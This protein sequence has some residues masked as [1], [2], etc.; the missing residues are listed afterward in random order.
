[1][2]V[3]NLKKI[4][5]RSPY[6]ISVAPSPDEGGDGSEPDTT[7]TDTLVLNRDTSCGSTEEVG[8]DVGVRK[9]NLTAAQRQLGDYTITFSNI[10][11]PIKFRIGHAD[12][13]PA[14]S[15]AGLDSY[16]AAWTTATGESPTLSSASANP[17]GVSAT[18]TY[19]STQSDIDTYGNTITLEIL[20]PLIVEGYSFVSSCPAALVEQEPTLTGFVT[21]L[22]VTG[23]KVGSDVTATIN[24]VS[25]PN[26]PTS[27][28]DSVRY[29]F[30]DETPNL[31]PKPATGNVDF[32]RDNFG[33]NPSNFIGSE[34]NY[35]WQMSF[36]TS[37]EYLAENR[38]SRGTNRVTFSRIE[39]TQ[40]I[41]YSFSVARHPVVDISGTNYILGKADEE[42]IQ[43]FSSTAIL[44]NLF[45]ASN[46]V[47]IYWDGGNTQELSNAS[48]GGVTLPVRFA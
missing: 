40:E 34:Y 32:Q 33:V 25:L 26:L 48:V 23:M 38:L 28:G 13:M 19:T 27:R 36:D 6:Y 21:V 31:V 39:R 14:Y 12:N 5:V 17:N 46:T 29:I 30:S 16:A 45:G 44:Y 11:V 4:N 43:V 10:K 18:A 35:R 15:T 41:G 1:M 3:N 42:M 7:P 9:Y 2:A 8:I 20:Q 24:N 22:T 47:D 37:V